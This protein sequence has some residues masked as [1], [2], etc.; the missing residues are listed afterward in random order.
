MYAV[1]STPL[2]S[3]RFGR[4]WTGWRRPATASVIIDLSGLRVIDSSGVG[5][6]VSLYKRVR[7]YGGHASVRGAKDQPL[8]IFKLLEAGPRAGARGGG[9]RLM[10]SSAA[11]PDP[12]WAALRAHSGRLFRPGPPSHLDGVRVGGPGHPGGAGHGGRGNRCARA[13]PSCC[14]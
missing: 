8:A 6:I 3:R 13:P 11:P 2:P 14:A 10:R 1:S 9:G 5:S 7:A 4:R 12:S